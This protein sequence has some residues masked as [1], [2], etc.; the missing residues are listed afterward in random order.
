MSTETKQCSI[1]IEDMNNCICDKETYERITGNLYPEED[2][3]DLG[4][5]S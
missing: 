5:S 3:T 4:F 1:C 2:Y